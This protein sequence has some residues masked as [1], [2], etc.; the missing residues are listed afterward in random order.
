MF[1]RLYTVFFAKIKA[2]SGSGTTINFRRIFIVA[3]IALLRLQGV[4][5]KR[6]RGHIKQLAEFLLIYFV[7]FLII[8]FVQHK[9][10]CA[11]SEFVSGLFDFETR[12]FYGRA[13]FVCYRHRKIA[14]AVTFD[15]VF[16]PFVA[17]AVEQFVD[18]LI[19]LILSR[20]FFGRLPL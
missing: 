10:I 7:V 19:H 3:R 11:E 16:N 5:V 6:Q 8:E 1:A 12:V 17:F 4:P 15:S 2:Q 13:V 9:N 18:F 20:L 14:L